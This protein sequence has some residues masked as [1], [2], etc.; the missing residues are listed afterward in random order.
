MSYLD[1]QEKKNLTG[2][3]LSVSPLKSARKSKKQYFTLDLE[4]DS[5]IKNIVCFSPSNRRL[6]SD[7][8]NQR[9]GWE[10][11]NVKLKSGESTAFVSDYSTV[12]QKELGFPCTNIYKY[13]SVADI[14]NEVPLNSQENVHAVVHV[15]DVKHVTVN[16]EEVPIR[17]AY[18]CD[19]CGN[20]RLTL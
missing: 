7:A 11:R 14:I 19:H 13:K 3:V 9:T 10:I 1:E 6:F 4:T 2:Y 16:N 18:L 8:I 12:H 5:N 17:E 15:K 20:I